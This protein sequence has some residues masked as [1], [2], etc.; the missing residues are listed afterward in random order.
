MRKDGGLRD[1]ADADHG[2][3]SS[4]EVHIEVDTHRLAG[5]AGAE[6]S[7]ITDAEGGIGGDG[8]AEAGFDHRRTADNGYTTNVEGIS[9]RG[10]THLSILVDVAEGMTPAEHAIGCQNRPAHVEGGRGAKPK[11]GE[12]RIRGARRAGQ[13]RRTAVLDE[14]IRVQIDVGQVGEGLEAR[15]AGAEAMGKLTED[16]RG[17]GIVAA[18]HAIAEAGEGD[19]P[20]GRDIVPSVGRA[21]L[22]SEIA[23]L[24]ATIEAEMIVVTVSGGAAIFHVEAA[25]AVAGDGAETP[26][27]EDGSVRRRR[28]RHRSSGRAELHC[29]CCSSAPRSRNCG[30]HR[31]AIRGGLHRQ[32]L[33]VGIG[34]GRVG[35]SNAIKGSA[36]AVVDGTANEATVLDHSGPGRD[37]HLA[38]QLVEGISSLGDVELDQRVDHRIGQRQAVRSRPVAIWFGVIPTLPKET[39]HLFT[40]RNTFVGS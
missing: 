6:L 39:L 28:R 9:S 22:D 29:R 32:R 2:G 1:V 18:L 37:M 36:Y 13:R 30:P 31:K 34:C 40:S 26:G 23:S 19:I 27:V 21:G 35:R 20:R 24:R 7:A 8:T 3:F 16:L 38:R 33:A 5:N 17:C 15:A 12:G 14:T 25:A 10:E 4:L 11:R